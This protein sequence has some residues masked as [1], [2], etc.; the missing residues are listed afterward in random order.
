MT[1]KLFKETKVLNTREDYDAFI[2]ESLKPFGFGD[3]ADVTLLALKKTLFTTLYKLTE[4]SGPSFDAE[5]LFGSF[6]DDA[7][8]TFDEVVGSLL[9]VQ[10]KKESQ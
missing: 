2:D 8:A 3:E 9:H 5:I 4:E 7:N 1:E 10:R 6:I